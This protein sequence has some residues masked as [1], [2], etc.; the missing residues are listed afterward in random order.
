MARQSS[1][2]NALSSQE[3]AL[4]SEVP[5]TTTDPV[6]KAMEILPVG[7]VCF[8]DTAGLDD[9]G[10]LGELRIKRTIRVLSHADV[11]L[12]VI[13]STNFTEEFEEG[14]L[15]KIQSTGIP[16]VAVINKS[17]ISSNGSN[18]KKLL[19]KWNL[20]CVKVSSKTKSG[21][22]ELKEKIIEAAK[23][24]ALEPPIA[25]DLIK[26]GDTVIT[27]IP[28]DKSAPKGRLILPQVM[29]IRDILDHDG[30]A[31]MVKEDQLLD[32]IKNLKEPPRLVITDS[33]VIDRV[34]RDTPCGIL[35]TSFSILFARY[36]GDIN[37]LV[38]GAKAVENLI[39]GDEILIAEACTHHPTSDDIG[40]SK[41]PRWLNARAG[42]ALNFN[43]CV[44][45]D[46]PPDLHRYKLVIHC[47]ACMINRKAMLQ[48]IMEARKCNVPIVNYG[49]LISYIHN[50]LEDALKCLKLHG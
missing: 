15:E 10:A 22:E 43:Y 23:P 1:L 2:I 37:T 3:T 6:Y 40:R 24:E 26:P 39:P 21:I 49:V 14:I 4:V 38:E 17:D 48:R 28:V 27:V 11:A 35:F 9:E 34:R 16:V 33:Q 36:R 47:G 29:T 41:I 50:V 8:I 45:G 13:D 32:T 12:L 25:G 44:G 20:S 30:R 7:P 42:G 31:I 18:I 46:F 5:G 19:E